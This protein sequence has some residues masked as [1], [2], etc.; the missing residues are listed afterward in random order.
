MCNK[1]KCF[2]ITPIGNEG[3]DVRMHVDGIIDAVLVP[4]VEDE[5]DFELEVSHRI[6]AT[7]NIPKQV[8]TSIFSSDLVIAN[9]TG[10]NPNVMYELALRH[11]FGTPAIIIAAKET[12]IPS[13]IISERAIFYVNDAQGVIDL[14]KD[15]RRMISEIESESENSNTQQGPVYD[16]LREKLNADSVIQEIQ[17]E[18]AV[19]M[20]SV[21]L[22]KIDDLEREIRNISVIKHKNINEQLVS[23]DSQ[24]IEII[25]SQSREN[26]KRLMNTDILPVL[27]KIGKQFRFNVLNRR[28]RIV[29]DVLSENEFMLVKDAIENAFEKYGIKDIKIRQNIKNYDFI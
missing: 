26:L 23:D 28:I 11:C 8:I 9:L 19:D 20:F 17:N 13:D 7:G 14:K 10:N 12:S 2:V 3:T 22:N 21:L 1:K 16:A 4:V 27:R 15:L 18:E 29:I 25:T 6:D 5:Y 24:I